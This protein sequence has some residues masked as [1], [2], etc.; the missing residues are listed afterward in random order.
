MRVRSEVRN[1]DLH[2]KVSEYALREAIERAYGLPVSASLELI[3]GS[4][5][6]EAMMELVRITVVDAVEA[7]L[8]DLSTETLYR[9][10]KNAEA[11]AVATAQI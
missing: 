2:I 3:F 7:H 10:M 11:R 9:H 5:G 8:R 1:G 4:A 6:A